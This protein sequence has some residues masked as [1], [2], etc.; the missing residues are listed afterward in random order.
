[1]DLTEL[2]RIRKE[3]ILNHKKKKKEYYLKKKLEQKMSSSG[4]SIKLEFDYEKELQGNIFAQTIKEIAKKQKTHVDSRK[5]KIIEKLLAYK[6][7]KQNYYKEN[8][9]KRLQYDKDYRDKKRD[10]LK[11]YRKEYYEK[12]RERILEKQ[13]EKRKL[14]SLNGK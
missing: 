12:N 13:K 9:E 1:M 5:D 11:E 4:N 3:N 10:E 7:Q 8:R 14:K 2:K 6:E